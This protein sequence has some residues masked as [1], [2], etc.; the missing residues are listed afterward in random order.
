MNDRAA[1][2][3]STP[4]GN[5]GSLVVVATP[6]GNLGDFSPRAVETLKS[7]S[8]VLAEDTRSFG[9]LATRFGIETP[10]L[11]FHEHSERGRI[12]PLLDRLRAG[13]TIALVSDAGTPTISD[14]GYR[15]VAACRAEGIPVHAV[16]GPCAALVALSISGLPT[17]RF[18][19]AGF[20]P[21][22][23]GRREQFLRELLGLGCTSVF[24]ESPFRLLSTLEMVCRLEGAREIFVARELTKKFEEHLFGS[25]EEVT[26]K[27]R[28]KGRIKGEIVV[29]VRGTSRNSL[30]HE[31][32]AADDDEEPDEH[33]EDGGESDDEPS[34]EG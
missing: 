32:S 6:I 24:Y 10:R 34:G 23:K 27:V 29:V 9:F 15:I 30:P 31:D 1:P 8:L 20:A 4:A 25:A 21:Q 26:R 18:L 22:K 2:S 33:H 3:S 13:E 19:V 5:G 12:A 28:A 16:P 14:P 7:A 11:S 17:D